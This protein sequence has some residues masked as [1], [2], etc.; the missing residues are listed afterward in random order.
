MK[1]VTCRSVCALHHNGVTHVLCITVLFELDR[2]D[3]MLLL[4]TVI[5][6]KIVHQVRVHYLLLQQVLLVEE[7]NDRG[8]L[9]PRVRDNCPKQGFALLHSVLRRERV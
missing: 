2:V 1:T 5:L 7:E 9:E 6:G 8:V 4:L 3:S